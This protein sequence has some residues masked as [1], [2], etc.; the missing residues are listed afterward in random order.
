MDSAALVALL[1]DIGAHDHGHEWFAEPVSDDRS[2]TGPSATT[3]AK[4]VDTAA[5]LVGHRGWVIY[6]DAVPLLA[7]IGDRVHWRNKSFV[8]PRSP[9]SAVGQML[10]MLDGAKNN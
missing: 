1:L 7:V 9:W 8:I 5:P 10:F 4:I 3:L 2:R 6:R